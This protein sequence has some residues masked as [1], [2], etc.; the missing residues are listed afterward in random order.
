MHPSLIPEKGKRDESPPSEH[1]EAQS[2]VLLALLATAQVRIKIGPFTS[3]PI[4]ALCDSGA[5]INL[6]TASVVQAEEL[7][8]QQ[9]NMRIIGVNGISRKLFTKKIRLSIA[10]AVQ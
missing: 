7:P 6:I 10:T 9:C 4:R 8:T 3:G 1:R 5:Q 2:N